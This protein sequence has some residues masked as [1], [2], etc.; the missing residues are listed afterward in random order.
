[1]ALLEFLCW[2]L[3]CNVLSNLHFEPYYL[4]AVTLLEKLDLRNYSLNEIVETK[5]YLNL[6]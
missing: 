1:M 3:D 2:V 6:I 4:K 5:K